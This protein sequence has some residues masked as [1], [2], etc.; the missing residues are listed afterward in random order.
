VAGVEIEVIAGLREAE[1]AF[2][3]PAEAFGPGPVIVVDVGGR[4][5]E[6][7][8][9]SSDGAIED[10]VS[11][12]IGSVRMTERFMPSDPPSAAEV[13]AT[14]RF[15]DATLKGAPEPRAAEARLVGVSGTVLALL[16][17]EL[18]VDDMKTL[19]ARHEGAA[20][21]ESFVRRALDELRSKP[22]KDR[23]RGTVLPPGRADVIV[24]GT[25][26]V[27]ALF[28][29]YRTDRMLASNRGVRYGL[30]YETA[31]ALSSGA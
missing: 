30:I 21:E 14:K 26:I 22:A 10:R 16:G 9:G 3:A 17:L 19:V 5:T 2:R 27:L 18:G 23:V 12:E 1:L 8:V 31:K 24:A 11:L 7:I 25:L 4:S 28:E 6:V 15:I 13:E 20:L 29:R